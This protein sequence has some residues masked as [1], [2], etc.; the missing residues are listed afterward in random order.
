MK[1]ND[2]QAR[3]TK[4]EIY[5]YRNFDMK[6][7]DMSTFP[8]PKPGDVID[9]FELMTVDGESVNLYDLLDKPVVLEAGSVTCPMYAQNVPS[10][11]QLS[12]QFPEIRFVVLYVREA[13]PGSR[14]LPHRSDNMKRQQASRLRKAYGDE[15]Q[16]LID[17]VKGTVHRQ[18]GA[19]PNS[20]YLINTN[21]TILFRSDWNEPNKLINVLE[22]LSDTPS[23][24]SEHNQPPNPGMWLTLRVL[25]RG[26]I[27]S[28]IDFMRTM[29][30]H[31]GHGYKH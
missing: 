13:H 11:Q 1:S 3:Q 4:P 23:E 20:L 21:G 15:R 27:D 8:G 14:T 10:M 18:I 16:V 17:N 9:N 31:F 26:G 28:V 25:L 24:Q 12:D 2:K 7:Y 29:P 30:S 22:R 19:L 5:N 6:Y